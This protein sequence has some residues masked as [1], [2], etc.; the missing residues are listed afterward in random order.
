MKIAKAAVV[1]LF[2]LFLLS[3]PAWAW[4]AE[5][6]EIVAII[7]A[8]DLKPTARSRVAQILGVPADTTRQVA[9]ISGG[10]RGKGAAEA[11]LFAAEG[12]KLVIGD[13]L[14]RPVPKDCP[15]NQ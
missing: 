9:L 6:H 12:A 3:P 4:F 13:V 8:D 7:A 14:D 1:G 10:E 11:R 5:G 2:G 15:R